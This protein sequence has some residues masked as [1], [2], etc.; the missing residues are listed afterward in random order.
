M[1][2]C[3]GMA[4]KYTDVLMGMLMMMYQLCLNC[5]INIRFSRK[6]LWLRCS[7]TNHDPKVILRYYLET[8][9]K[10]KGSL[11][12]F[13]AMFVI[14]FACTGCPTTVRMDYGTENCKVAATQFAFRAN[15]S[16]DRAGERSYIYGSSHANV[17]GYN[18]FVWLVHPSTSL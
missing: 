11:L 13:E 9:E 18:F 14:T 17:V 10:V 1:I 5:Q 16:D 4:S 7:A 12:Q 3:L 6:V 2:S 8:V 15:H